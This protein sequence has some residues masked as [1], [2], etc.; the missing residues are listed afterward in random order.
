MR[1]AEDFGNDK[2]ADRNHGSDRWSDTPVRAL[3]LEDSTFDRRRILRMGDRMERD[4]RID[5]APDLATLRGRVATKDYDVILLDYALG[6]DTGLEALDA[7]DES[8]GNRNAAKIMITGS[9]RADLAVSALKQ[10]CHDFLVKENLTPDRLSRAIDEAL[11][12]SA[13]R[14][15]PETRVLG[16]NEEALRDAVLSAL[17]GPAA[18]AALQTPLTEGLREAAAMIG[19]SEGIEDRRALQSFLAGFLQTDEFHFA[20]SGSGSAQ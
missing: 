17:S 13:R 12:A 8:P 15:A 5:E 11:S 1:D 14:R 10:G 19:L 6:R 16:L 2:S 9:A 20:A 3:L 18:R 4:L 7:I